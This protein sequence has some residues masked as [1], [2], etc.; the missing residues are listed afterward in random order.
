MTEKSSSPWTVVPRY[1]APGKLNPAFPG[2]V[3]RTETPPI[4]SLAQ[5]TVNPPAPVISSLPQRSVPPSDL[6]PSRL[7]GT[8]PYVELEPA[9][10]LS[11]FNDDPLFKTRDAA[12]ILGLTE[13]CLKKWRQRGQGPT[14]LQYRMVIGEPGAVRYALSALMQFRESHTV[15][16]KGKKQE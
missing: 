7:I 9:R 6:R 12:V 15:R 1:L 8:P 16:A 2:F 4:P 3:P 5:P 11:A 14:Y 10:P 13:D